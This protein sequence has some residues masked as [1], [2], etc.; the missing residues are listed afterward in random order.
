MEHAKVNL[1]QYVQSTSQLENLL[2][3]ANPNQDLM[4]VIER[5]QTENN[6]LMLQREQI[7]N[8]YLT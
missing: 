5:L 6:T 8:F 3:N 1:L 7:N 4:L 2:I